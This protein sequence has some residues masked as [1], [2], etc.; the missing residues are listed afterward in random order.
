MKKQTN[1]LGIIPARA[2]SK[3]L[4]GKN[5]KRL[6][7]KELVRYA[8]ETALGS[9]MVNDWVLSSDDEDIINI[10]MTYQQL[11]VLQRPADISGDEALAITYVKHALDEMPAEYSHIVIVQV[12]SPFTKPEDIDATIDRLLEKPGAN[13][14]V[15]VQSIDFAL[16]PAKI[17]TLDQD[18]MLR[19]YWEAENGRMSAQQLPQ[20]Y[21]RNGSV[22]VST[23]DAIKRGHIVEEPCA[24]HLMPRERSLDINDPIDFA[25]AEFLMKSKSS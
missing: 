24:A 5:K 14:A 11:K 21:V 23:I 6:A 12:T 3:R 9:R 13:S 22:Y 19:A 2:G 16:H 20:L 7:G 18:G 4:P 1:I 25:F 10:G 17:K 15:S 8:I